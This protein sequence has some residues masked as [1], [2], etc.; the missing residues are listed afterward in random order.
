MQG[1]IIMHRINNKIAY[2]TYY[3]ISYWRYH[4]NRP[5]CASRFSLILLAFAFV[6]LAFSFVL[7]GV[8]C[9]AASRFSVSRKVA[10]LLTNE[11]VGEGSK[12]AREYIV[13]A[14]LP[15]FDERV[16][17]WPALDGFFERLNFGD[18][19]Y[20]LVGTSKGFIMIDVIGNVIE[21]V[22]E[23]VEGAFEVG[24]H[25]GDVL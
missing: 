14:E 4:L 3:N 8:E 5:T 18:V 12:I 24:F 23:V 16:K 9:I 20:L 6:S 22:F 7:I 13:V 11:V 10:V 15:S 1:E 19:E 17:L 25:S 21:K 2:L